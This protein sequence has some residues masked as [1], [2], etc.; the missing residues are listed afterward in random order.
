[1][2]TKYDNTTPLNNITLANGNLDMNTNQIKNVVDPVDPQ[3]VVT[4]AYGDA[5]YLGGGGSSPSYIT[6][7]HDLSATSFTS[8]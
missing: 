3:D 7:K 2:D 8:G 6:L 4:K 5:N 1:M